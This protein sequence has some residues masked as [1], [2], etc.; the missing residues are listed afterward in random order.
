M[1]G[2]VVVVVLAIIF[3]ILPWP[4]YMIGKK[5][6]VSHPWVA[7]IPIVG[8]SIVWLWS[9]DR[10]GWMTLIAFIPLV[11]IVFSI[12]LC[13]GMP[14]HHG[15]TRWWGVPLLFLPWLGTLIYAITLDN[16]TSAAPA[17]Y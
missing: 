12:W 6:R 11:N 1:S 3:V 8:Y 7:F 9:M 13:F 2:L 15:R 17:L 5:R 10:S 14:P 16:L 4:I